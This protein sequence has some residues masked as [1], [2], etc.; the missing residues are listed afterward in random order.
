[1]A[2]PFDCLCGTP[3]CRGR[4][5]GARD[6]TSTQLDGLW[7]NGHIRE[8]LEERENPKKNQKTNGHH[9]QQ[10]NG[11][12]TTAATSADQTVLALRDA[13]AHAEKVVDAARLALVSYVEAYGH[14][15]NGN[16]AG[17]VSARASSGAQRRGPT[18]RELSGEMGGDTSVHV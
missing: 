4:I 6:M 15:A 7:L 11:H 3:T 5:A 13:L 2:Q 8:L 16:G 12:T 9:H 18:S 17:P 10:Q 1:M 14:N